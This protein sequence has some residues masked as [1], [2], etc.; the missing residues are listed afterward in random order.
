MGF[1]TLYRGMLAVEAKT[2]SAQ[3][4]VDALKRLL[5]MPVFVESMRANYGAAGIVKPYVRKC[6]LDVA[7]RVGHVMPMPAATSVRSH[8]HHIVQRL[9]AHE[10]TSDPDVKR[11]AQ[12]AKELGADPPVLELLCQ[13]ADGTDERV[14]DL[15]HAALSSVVVDCNLRNA[16]VMPWRDNQSV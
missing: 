12:V 16:P 3:P 2:E 4:R 8:I 5:G 15:V 9:A 1:D 6:V 7:G 11:W 13:I 14:R 10:H